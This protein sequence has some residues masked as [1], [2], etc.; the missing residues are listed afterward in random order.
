MQRSV[1][2]NRDRLPEQRVALVAR[3]HRRPP[4][5]RTGGQANNDSLVPSRNNA[6]R[7]CEAITANPE[8]NK[9]VALLSRI[10]DQLD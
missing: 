1:R 5:H 9:V 3:R 7:I 10:S 8:L 6:R 2:Q 4:G